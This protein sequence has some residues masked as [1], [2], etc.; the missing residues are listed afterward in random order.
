M[1]KAATLTYSKELML[2]VKEHIFKADCQNDFK[3]RLIALEVDLENA[4]PM[5]QWKSA[6]KPSQNKPCGN[7]GRRLSMRDTNQDLRTQSWNQRASK[8]GQERPEQVRSLQNCQEGSR[9]PYEGNQRRSY[10]RNQDRRRPQV[11][12]T[13]NSQ[14]SGDS[15]PEVEIQRKVVQMAPTRRA[16]KAWKPRRAATVDPVA[17]KAK[18]IRG[19]LN[20]ITPTTFEALCEQFLSEEVFKNELLLPQV[21]DVIFEKA[22]EEP[23]FC[24]LYSDLV[25]KQIQKERVFGSKAFQQSIISRCQKTFQTEGKGA[26]AD[27]IA[28]RQKEVDEAKDEIQKKVAQEKLNEL[29]QKERRIVIG[30]IGLIAQFHRHKL[31]NLKILNSCIAHLLR[32]NEVT[33]GGDE[34]SLKCAIKLISDVGKHWETQRRE[35]VKM[36]KLNP[37]EK[38][39][40]QIDL[41]LVA[42]IGYLNKKSKDFVPKMRFAVMDLVALKNNNW[43]PRHAANGPKTKAQIQADVQNEEQQKKLERQ[44]Y[45]DQKFQKKKFS[46]LPRLR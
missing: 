42:Y 45:D 3:K 41:D 14:K 17:A 7:G 16:E 40:V 26:F 32:E 18:E 44:R 8:E 2:R 46:T 1:C 15:K 13:H 4:P 25:N 30:N 24:P 38:T 10:S 35:Q 12:R 29:K 43:E 5:R 33:E 9:R 28:E 11:Q 37:S 31:L 36:M 21:V 20:K 34:E 23:R 22:V 6:A 27:K 19:L 39:R